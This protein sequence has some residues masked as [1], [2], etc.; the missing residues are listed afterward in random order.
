MRR[1]F[2]ALALAVLLPVPVLAADVTV[3]P[4]ETLSDIA[5][6]YGISLTRLMKLN[7]IAKADHI[8]VGQVLKVPG[9]ARGTAGRGDGAT[10][11]V[12]VREG[13]TLSEIAARQGMGL[14]QLMALNGIS[15]ADHVE[16]GQ[17]LKVTGKPPVAAPATAGAR[18]CTSC[19]PAR[20]SPRSPRA[21]ASR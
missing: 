15:K 9:P 19:A 12:T 1:S 21:T 3:K 11:S 2:V 14:G 4:G 8:E 7:G 6:R 10:G 17:V 13:E 20:A 5:A 18:M 16:V